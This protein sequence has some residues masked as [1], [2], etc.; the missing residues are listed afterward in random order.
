LRRELSQPEFGRDEAP[1]HSSRFGTVVRMSPLRQLRRGWI[2]LARRAPEN[3]R[4]TFR[5]EL[6]AEVLWEYGEDEL[7]E[8]ALRL[9]ERQLR[10]IQ[11]LTAWHEINDPDPTAGPKLTGGRLMARAAI[12]YIEGSGRDTTRRRRRTRPDDQRYDA[13]YTAVVGEGRPPSPST[14]AEAGDLR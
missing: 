5:R 8:R 2:N 3:F 4:I 12:D 11:R 14:P 1:S 7:A 10:R 9:K 6:L 13:A